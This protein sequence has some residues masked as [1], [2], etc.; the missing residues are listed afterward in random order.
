MKKVM[1]SLTAFCALSA[2]CSKKAAPS[3]NTS[4]S[5]TPVTESVS[6]PSIPAGTFNISSYG[7]STGSSNNTT[8]VLNAINAASAA[9][10][11]TVVVPSGT[12]LCGPIKLKNNVGLQLSSGAVLKALPYGTYP[13][14][15]GTA[16]VAAFID[17]TGLTNVKVSRRDHGRAG[18]RLVDGL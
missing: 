3:D 16:D 17:L 18:L 4:S 5:R 6:T 12:F 8:A 7:A 15:G 9:G 10:G 2:A 14:S 11:G 1:V 13:G